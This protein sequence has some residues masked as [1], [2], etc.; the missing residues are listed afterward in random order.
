LVG[1]LGL[2]ALALLLVGANIS[3]RAKYNET[4][5]ST[6]AAWGTAT[7]TALIGFTLTFG[8]YWELRQDVPRVLEYRWVLVIGGTLT[9]L[10][11]LYLFA[12]VSQRHRAEALVAVRTAELSE[13]ERR[14]RGLFEINPEPMWV[15]DLETL[16]F[17]AVNDMAV[18]R[19]GY[20]R[21]EFLRMTVVDIHPP[22]D[23]PRLPAS[24]GDR[25]GER[26]RER[27]CRHQQRDGT[28]IDVEIS[29]HPL[30]FQ[31]RRA[32]LVLVR[33]ITERNRVQQ[34]L[35]ENEERYRIVALMTG[36]LIYDYDC[37]AGDIRWAGAIAA[38]TGYSDS[39]FAD[40]NI[41]VW[42]GMI[43]P[44]DRS[45][46][47]ESL[48]KSM[49]AGG[50]Y[51]VEYRLRRK[52]GQFIWVEDNGAFLCGSDGKAYRM[53]GTM[54]DIGERRG[55]EQALRDSEERF[56]TL[57]QASFGGI[58]IHDR[59]IILDCNQG[60]ADMTGYSMVELTGMN[61]L[62]LIAPEW[63]SLVKERI[64]G[65]Y[66]KSYEAQGLRK[67]GILY[68]LEIRGKSIPY[69]GRTARVTEFRDITERKRAEERQRLAAAVFEA[70]REAIVVID[71]S[72]NIV[73]VNPA[74][75]AMSG[76]AEAEVLGQSPRFLQS[77]RQSDAYYAA[78]WQTVAREGTWQGEFWSRR[79]EGDLF[80][81]LTTVGE[82]R[83]SA[84]RLTHY[85]IIATDI[86]HQKE[87]EK[88]I[89]HL[90]YYDALTDLP[91]RALLAQR[92][93]LALALAA[94]R[95]E[96][97]VVMFLDLD[98]FKEVNDSLGHAEG[99][100]LLI[101]VAARLRGL[102]R[103]ADTI[104]RLGGDE[105]VLLLPG[106]G[107]S[108]AQ[109]MA[110]K[111]MNA[112]GQP[113]VVAGHNLRVT[114]SVGIALYPHDGTD[115][116][117]LLKN[118]DAALYHAKQE[119][120]NVWAFYA[121]EMNVATFERLMLESQLRKAVETGQLCVHYQPKI[122]LADGALVGAE[123]LIR[124]QHPD[125][126]LIAPGRF[127]PV[128]E[129]SDLIVVI[130]NWVLEAV[131]RQLAAWRGAGLLLPNVA[132]NLAA[133]HFRDPGLTERIQSL[134]EAY[135]LA[136]QVL[137]L[138]LTESTLLEVGART[139]DTLLALEH[140]GVG[141]AIDDFGTGYSSLGYLKRL[142]I[143]ALKIDQS[144][145]RDLVIDPDDR[146]LAATIIALGHSLGLAV[147][148]EG[149]ETE[150]QQSI[151]LDQGCDFAQGYLFSAPL[152]A[153]EFVEWMIRRRGDR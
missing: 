151:L 57:Y 30:Q 26:G 98:R 56:R 28:V 100:M 79:K 14:Y 147:V 75:T 135:G 9:A 71:A 63:R 120:R 146:I 21:D 114:V 122:R 117:A 15:Y 19:Y 69:R 129:A 152:P 2:A 87:A 149:L 110:D 133:R 44:D 127:I 68:P 73:A 72:G 109:R 67:D 16:C 141:L 64:A 148:A 128:A 121:R 115:F 17:L 88:R 38:I 48:E 60:L 90:A 81:A 12:L 140:L 49:A 65:E 132:V 25:T 108:G 118:A 106:V 51:F 93:D 31:G 58:G 107:Q 43:H 5:T 1:A 85:V 13:S 82:V 11:G 153:E 74:F 145:V 134:L 4:A 123:A 39:E 54:K 99:D 59:G 113:F 40:V 130:G 92:A 27:E 53:L 97:L 124:W 139:A 45:A 103:E 37:A 138:E 119:G 29:S 143:T 78:L 18:I 86:T 91:N 116:S 84:N 126:G 32:E 95:Q 35:R 104:C 52:D 112:F 50:S 7:L 6:M 101:Q 24:I 46:A 8:L 94:R 22:A 10:L 111:L 142:P 80:V 41:D 3:S 20:S 23:F 125:Y 47:L 33:D 137:E 36:Q 77:D 61:G 105:F 66:E 42:A 62:L 136:P 89:E 76:Y 34:T 144:F 131:C 150:E 70:A 102:T 96:E 55:A 83:D